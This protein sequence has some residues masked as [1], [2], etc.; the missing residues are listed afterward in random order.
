MIQVSVTDW[1]ASLKMDDE[2]GYVSKFENAGYSRLEDVEHLK[3]ITEEEL[4]FVI[5]VVKPGMH[6]NSNVHVSR[7]AHNTCRPQ[8]KA[9]ASYKNVEDEI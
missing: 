3:D 6:Y 4:E 2:E 8:K 5:G 7:F 1:L 9:H